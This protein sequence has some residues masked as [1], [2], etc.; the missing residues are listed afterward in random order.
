MATPIF[1][2]PRS[3]T[4]KLAVSVVVL[5]SAALLWENLE[6]P[7]TVSAAGS[8]YYVDATAGLDTKDGKSPE[9]AWQTI[10][11]VNGAALQPGDKVLFKRGD[12]WRGGLFAPGASG[13]VN[14]PIVFGSYGPTN[15]P[16]PRISGGRLAT[17]WQGPNANGEYYWRAV[18]FGQNGQIVVLEDGRRLTGNNTEAKLPAPQKGSL[19]SGEWA[20]DTVTTSVYYKPT[21]GLPSGHELEI[22]TNDRFAFSSNQK[23][24]V[25][26]EDLDLYGGYSYAALIYG[27]SHHVSIRNSRMHGSDRHG[28]RITVADDNKLIGNEIYDAN[29]YGVFI[30][31]GADRNLISGNTVHD[32]GVLRTDDGDSVGIYVGGASTVTR[33]LSSIVTHNTVRQIGKDTYSGKNG[34]LSRGSLSGTGILIESASNTQITNN[35]IY[36]IARTGIAVFSSYSDSLNLAIQGNLLYQIGSATVVDQI[37]S[38]ILLMNLKGKMNGTSVLNNT[39]ADSDFHSNSGREAALK[40]RVVGPSGG[41][42]GQLS[43]LTMR[44]NLI[45]GNSANYTLAVDVD[46]EAQVTNLIL[47]NNLYDP[48]SGGGVFWNQGGVITSFAADKI[49]G[50]TGAYYSTAKQNDQ[51]SVAASPLFVEAAAG[52]YRLRQQSPAVDVGADVGLT[53]DIDGNVIPR[54][55]HPDVGAYESEWSREPVPPAIYGVSSGVV[56]STVVTATYSAGVATLSKNGGAK[57]PYISGSEIRE[58]GSYLLRV[59]ASGGLATEV[60]FSIVFG[61]IIVKGVAEGHAYNYTVKPV[62]PEGTGTLRKNG[63]PPEPFVSGAP[64][65]QEGEYVLTIS[66]PANRSRSVAFAIDR[67]PPVISSVVNGAVYDQPVMPKFNE[68][69]AILY[70]I[71]SDIGGNR[72]RSR[73]MPQTVYYSGD[74]PSGLVERIAISKVMVPLSA[75]D[76]EIVERASF[77]SGMAVSESGRYKLTVTDAVYN[78]SVVRFAIAASA[79]T[80]QSDAV[81]AAGESI[82]LMLGVHGV[83]EL[84]GLDVKLDYD[85]NVLEYVDAAGIRNGV[86]VAMADKGNDDG[87]LHMLLA[88]LGDAGMLEGDSAIAKVT[89]RVSEQALAGTT[90]V[91]VS[92][93]TGADMKGREYALSLAS[94]MISVGTTVDKEALNELIAT[95]ASVLASAT[96]GTEVGEYWPGSLNQQKALL[97]AAIAVAEEVSGSLTATAGQ[98]QAATTVL[99]EAIAAFTSWKITATAGDLNGDGRISIGDLALIAHYYGKTSTNT[100]GEEWSLIRG[101]DLNRD[102]KIDLFELTYV[103]RRI[104]K[105]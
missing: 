40:L 73:Y 67:T 58:E 39:I 36:D 105:R 49:V 48:A 54:G 102:G 88:A 5:L 92:A 104:I 23:S 96:E 3:Q 85:P 27:D 53:V 89:F 7:S 44:N 25:E 64:V 69:T 55:M 15:L 82:E 63:G 16:L 47:D 52:N 17:D 84:A 65:T 75:I 13:T 43:G 56:Y 45:S 86:V 22:V 37:S 19:A 2:W 68:G 98:V 76:R 35:R 60:S 79:V 103:A 101:Y 28:V 11:K 24:Y 78:Q 74:D 51:H 94:R 42:S 97:A 10:S 90:N 72:M 100:S 80:L 32:I 20:W 62:F 21:S 38:G 26:L 18:S 29:F 93:A 9:T 46:N 71:E 87:H 81:V 14:N 95:A 83:T 66:V 12:I 70:R 30:E 91:S 61:P 59:E 34:N 77:L 31:N 4:L 6:N 99:N 57:L 41:N 1:R 33:P 50:I 8:V